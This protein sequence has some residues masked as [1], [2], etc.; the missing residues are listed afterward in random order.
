MNR[1]D[2]EANRAALREPDAPADHVERRLRVILPIAMSL[3]ARGDTYTERLDCVEST[4][5]GYAADGSRYRASELDFTPRLNEASA[6]S[7]LLGAVD[8]PV[9]SNDANR[10]T[11]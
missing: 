8:A 9:V 5:K 4:S 6:A 2:K 7:L 11:A 3:S 10:W 1:S